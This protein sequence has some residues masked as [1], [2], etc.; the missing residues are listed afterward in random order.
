MKTGR[1]LNRV[2]F[3]FSLHI[4]IKE[5]VFGGNCNPILLL[6]HFELIKKKKGRKVILLETFAFEPGLIF[7]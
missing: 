6:T 4:F 5:D 7:P 2:F 3:F 1:V